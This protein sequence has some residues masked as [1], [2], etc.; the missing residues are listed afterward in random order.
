MLLAAVPSTAA[1]VNYVNSSPITIPT[2]GAASPFPSTITPSIDPSSTLVVRSVTARLNGYWHGRPE[3]V[4]VVLVGPTG[5]RVMLVSDAGDTD[6]IP[7]ASKKT[8]TFSDAAPG[9]VPET[10]EPGNG[11]FKPTDYEPGDGGPGYTTSLASFNGTSPKGA[12]NL[13]VLDDSAGG[14]GGAIDGGWVLSL[15]TDFAAADPND[16]LPCD[17]EEDPVGCPDPNAPPVVKPGGSVSLA[18]VL[19]SNGFVV[20]VKVKKSGS[21]LKGSVVKRPKRK[22]RSKSA[23]A[24]AKKKKAFV[25]AKGRAKRVPKGTYRLRLKPTK[26]GAKRLKAALAK[27]TSIKLLAKVT[28]DPPGKGKVTRKSVKLTVKR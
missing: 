16:P 15:E 7:Q 20:S 24:A 19:A 6:A 14:T 12:W 11:S 23:S 3:D 4:D 13:Y 22:K 18:D 17:P 25:Y 9:F 21:A 5:K 8:M 28:I 1:A 10:T 27:R 2:E 26:K